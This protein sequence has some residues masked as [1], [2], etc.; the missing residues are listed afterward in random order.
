MPC[1][2]SSSDYFKPAFIAQ[3]VCS[4]IRQHK[5]HAAENKLPAATSDGWPEVVLV[6]SAEGLKNQWV[7]IRYKNNTYF[8]TMD[9]ATPKKRDCRQSEVLSVPDM[10]FVLALLAEVMNMRKV[11]PI[12]PDPWEHVAQLHAENYPHSERDDKFDLEQQGYTVDEDTG[13]NNNNN[14]I[15]IWEHNNNNDVIPAFSQSSQ[16][17]SSSSVKSPTLAGESVIAEAPLSLSSAK[18]KKA[19]KKR[20]YKRKA[21]SDNGIAAFHLTYFSSCNN[22]NNNNNNNDNSGNDSNTKHTPDESNNPMVE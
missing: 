11:L 17:T 9:K 7:V 22:N 19:K 13:C 15:P 5:S 4:E 3:L 1:R 12:G 2:K 10:I 6:I 8:Y 20:S 18:S 21:I 14:Y 16:L